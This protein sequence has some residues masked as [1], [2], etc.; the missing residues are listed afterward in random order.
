[1]NTLAIPTTAHPAVLVTDQLN[2]EW[3]RLGARPV[4]KRWP[5]PGLAGC[6]RLAD[7]ADT[8]ARARRH[9]PAEADGL[10]VGLLDERTGRDDHLAGRLVL[11]VML[12]RAVKLARGTHRFGAPGVRGDL[13]QLTAAAVTALWHA[14]ATYPVER[15]RNKVAVNLCMDALAHFNA[16]LQD[17]TP[18]LVATTI[19][20]TAEPVFRRPPAP[21]VEVFR[22]LTWGI[23]TGVITADDA[24]LLVRVYCPL[25]GQLGG[26]H[27]VAR[28]IGL[29]AATVRQRCSRA[30]Q[31]MS[32]AVRVRRAAIA[33]AA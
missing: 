29:P 27:Q 20:D 12:G 22:A 8:I 4:P 2:A 17:D 1:M 9:Q 31:R 19:L 10:L 23:S 13:P 24:E 6:A 28:E 26:A 15:R 30:I 25:P 14:I 32:D 3:L 7:V 16:A 21:V 5:L 11:Q 33:T 18:D